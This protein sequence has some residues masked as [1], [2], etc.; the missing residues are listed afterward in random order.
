MKGRAC[1]DRYGNPC[2]RRVPASWLH[3]TLQFGG[4]VSALLIMA[5]A[6]RGL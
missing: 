2:Y 5:L 1:V 4:V 6:Y 3:R